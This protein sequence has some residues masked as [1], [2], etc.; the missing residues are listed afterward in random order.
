MKVLEH[1]TSRAAKQDRQQERA[2][3]ARQ[4]RSS[5][6]MREQ[7]R[8]QINAT[9]IISEII[10]IDALLQPPKDMAGNPIPPDTATTAALKARADIKFKL[11][12]KVLPDLKATESINH[13][14]HDHQHAHAHTTVSNMELAQRLQLWRRSHK[15]ED[16]PTVINTIESAPGALNTDKDFDFL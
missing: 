3:L 15:I 12:G 6:M 4:L 8:E 7:A 13:S 1:P 16:D 5:Q 11:L 14:T 9:Q 10:E 2:N